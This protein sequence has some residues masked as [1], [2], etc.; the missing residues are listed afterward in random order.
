MNAS[1]PV[2]AWLRAAM[3]GQDVL[4]MN[5]SRSGARAAGRRWAE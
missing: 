5:D 3:S 1:T 2:T 4:V